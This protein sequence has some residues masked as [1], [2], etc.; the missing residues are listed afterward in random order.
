MRLMRSS[1]GT[2]VIGFALVTFAACALGCGT[3]GGTPFLRAYSA[4]DR[5]YS[6]GRFDDADLAY[7]DA[8]KVA[9][10]PRDREESLYAAADSEFR[11]GH[12]DEA[13]RT[14]DQLSMAEPRGER[15][16]R[17]S[18]R[19]ARIRIAAG[20]EAVGYRA[21]QRILELAPEHGVSHR[22]LMLV[23]AHIEATGGAEAA[24][25]WEASFLPRVADTRLGEEITYDMALRRE[26]TG[27]LAGA[28]R[29]FLACA[30]RYRYPTGAL[31]DD[32]LFHASVLHER[33]GDAQGAVTDLE[34]MLS[35][36]ETSLMNG[37]YD[38][39]RMPPAQLRIGELQHRLLHDH[40]KARESFHR[41]SKEFP[42]SVL[43][44]KSLFLEAEIARDDGDTKSACALASNL[45][46][47]FADSRY[48]R[49]ADTLCTAF[50]PR[51]AALRKILR[52]RRDGR[53][54]HRRGG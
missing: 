1:F 50:A 21:L 11:A 44:A 5:A 30:D 26:S 7:R 14:F 20:D 12:I 9:E 22:A 48:A 33:L 40:A 15:S 16:I 29:G 35:V 53:G 2:P 24:L 39:P 32:A 23:T 37:S 49:R 41:L 43:R 10:R 54:S 27:D 6:A 8:S 13:L 47:D 36:H 45:V 28:L 52:E 4:G 31:F 51:A 46:D 25:S 38:R 18:Y 19:A 17:A 3:V 34:R 42:H